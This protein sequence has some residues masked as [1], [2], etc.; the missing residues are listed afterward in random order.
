VSLVAI[1]QF[2][3]DNIKS[4]WTL[5]VLL[6]L[7]AQPECSPTRR[8]LVDNLRASKAIVDKSLVALIATGLVLVEEGDRV[9][10]GPATADLRALVEKVREEYATR[11]DAIRRIIV[12]AAAS[13]AAAFAEAFRL[14]KE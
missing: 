3:R 14:R 11:P 9:R 5:E 6:H 2:L 7:A 4:V 1:E 12:S 13:S 10:Y 8:E